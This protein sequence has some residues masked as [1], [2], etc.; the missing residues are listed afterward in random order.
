MNN[1]RNPLLEIT[2]E[3]SDKNN[4]LGRSTIEQ[5]VFV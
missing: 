3:S 2:S 5:K 1:G 4:F